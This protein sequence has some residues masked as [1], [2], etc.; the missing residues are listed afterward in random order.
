MNLPTDR[1]FT[2]SEAAASGVTRDVLRSRRFRR[3]LRGVY[4]G[5]DVALTLRV[6]LLAVLLVLPDDC[7]VS[8]RTALALWGHDTRGAGLEL[9][10]R[11]ELRT[12]LPGVVLHRRMHPIQTVERDGLRVTTP[13][14]TFVDCATRLGI[15]ALVQAA[16]HLLR[17]ATTRNVL[18]TFCWTHHLHG[19]V[20]ARR[21][22]ALVREGAESPMES[23]LR[24]MLVFA[25]LP[26]P[27]VNVD[28]RDAQG[29]FVARVDLLYPRWKV[30]VEYDGRHHETDARQWARDR[31][32]REA[33]EALGYRVIVVAAADL[34]EPRHIPWR[35]HRALVERGYDGPRPVTSV[36]WL[37]WFTRAPVVDT[38][39][40]RRA[41]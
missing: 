38:S 4:V 18:D 16:E 34:A 15:V 40:A 11:T 23:L 22:M 12:R 39:G 33:L 26:E 30:V 35:V 3:L 1:P 7:A 29:R 31:W 37:R 14:R 41:A 24:L 36:Q 21:A 27:R 32:R 20:R 10:T 17:T 13:E 9:S 19:V 28:V 8:H 5:A 2:V 6:R 25:R